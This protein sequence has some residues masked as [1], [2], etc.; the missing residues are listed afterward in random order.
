MRRVCVFCGSKTGDNA[1]FGAAARELAV[2][3]VR[4]RLDLVYGGGNVG[5][6]GLLADT[7]LAAGGSVIGVIPRFMVLRELAHA[8]LTQL[9]LVDSMHERKALMAEHADGFIALPG[10][11]GTADELFEMLTWRQLHL[12]EKPIGVLNVG[13]FFDPLL[14]WLDTMVAQG[15]VKRVNRDL[16][17]VRTDCDELLS[18]MS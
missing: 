15:F 10:G 3:L 5:L 13:G 17:L 14:A 16:L 1:R 11:F 8:H 6:M 7:V 12:H 18:A 2:A 9:H 4:R